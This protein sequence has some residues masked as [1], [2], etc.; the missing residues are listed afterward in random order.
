MNYEVKLKE[1]KDNIDKAKDLKNRAEGQLDQLKTQEK[2]YLEELEKLGV[3]PKNLETEISNLKR[4]IENML[5]EADSM[6]PKE[7][8]NRSN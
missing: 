4:D 8:L 7:L 1:L 5:K 2:Q 3:D 6:I